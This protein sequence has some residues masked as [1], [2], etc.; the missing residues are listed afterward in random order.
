MWAG[1][2]AA[3]LNERLPER[4]F[5]E[6]NVQLGIEIDVATFEESQG[7]APCSG[8]E[9]GPP[10]LTLP[11]Q[12]TT[13]VVEVCVYGDEAGPI[14]V[15][16]IELVSPA[17][18]DRPEHRDAFLA[19][20]QTCLQQGLGLV[21]VDVVTNRHANLHRELVARL[22]GSPQG[23]PPELY[24]SAYHPLEREGSSCL[25]LWEE[26]LTLGA[27]LPTMPLWLRGVGCYPVDLEQTYQRTCR[28]LRLGA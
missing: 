14:L 13:D 18:K 22:G 12:R 11:F 16:A 2:I 17:N 27:A 20:C 1:F 26:A 28:E 9:A 6:P 8:W 3:A 23:P 25:D 19:K 21:V 15:G 24:A 5:A 10:A 4:F 7:P